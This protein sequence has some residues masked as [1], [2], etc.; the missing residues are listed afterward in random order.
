MCLRSGLKGDLWRIIRV[1]KTRKVSKSGSIMI[2][3]ATAGI[4]S[5]RNGLS[6]ASTCPRS[7]NLMVRMAVTIPMSKEP[8]SP[9]KIF[10]GVML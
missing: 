10:A 8:V 3:M 9:M 5:K 4:F 7:M 6:G 2:P 1:I